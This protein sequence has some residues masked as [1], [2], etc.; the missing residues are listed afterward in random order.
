MS[1]LLPREHGAYAQLG[2]PLLT[3]LIYARGDGGALGFA[4]AAIALFLAHEPVAV[5]A[6]VRG[7]RLQEQLAGPARRRVWALGAAAA[8]GLVA[9]I[10][11]ATPRAWLAAILPGGLALLLLP[12]LG[13]RKLKSIPAEILVAALFSTSTLPLAL[14]G[15]ATWSAAGVAAAVWFAAVLPAIFSVHGIKVAFKGKEEGRWTVTAAPVSAALVVLGALA[16]AAVVRPHGL[17]FLAVIPPALA[18][19][20]LSWIRPHPKHLKR[21]GWTMVAADTMTLVLLLVL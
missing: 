8:L 5:L 20:V 1:G 3:G 21:V 6:G 2:F 9:A 10:G 14:C 7:K 4:V 19:L 18:V 13:T 17:D 15:P 16:A 12:L 11:L